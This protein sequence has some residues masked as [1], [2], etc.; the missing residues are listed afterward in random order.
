MGLLV[1]LCEKEDNPEK[2]R[3]GKEDHVID[4]KIEIFVVAGG[5]SFPFG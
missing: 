3:I 5:I 4:Q 1:T 2:L